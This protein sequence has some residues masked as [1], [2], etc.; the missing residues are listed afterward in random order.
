MHPLLKTTFVAL[1][2]GISAAAS[3]LADKATA[4]DC[5]SVAR[6]TESEGSGVG[7]VDL[8]ARKTESEGSGVGS[9]DLARRTESEGSGVGSVSQSN[10]LAAATPCK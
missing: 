10:R 8:S 5:S 1:L 3:A 6:P 4:M 7:S 2:L 9:V